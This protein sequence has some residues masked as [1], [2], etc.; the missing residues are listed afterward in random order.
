MCYNNYSKGEVKM[1][2]TKTI[3][4]IEEMLEDEECEETKTIGETEEEC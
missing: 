4:Q 2:P 1:K 3:E